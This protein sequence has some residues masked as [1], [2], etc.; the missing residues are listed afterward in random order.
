MNEFVFHDPASAPPASRPLLESAAGKFGFVPSLLAGLAE[1]PSALRAYLE[2]ADRFSET[3]LSP[4]EQQVVAL[5]VSV[6]NACRFCV[7]A[8]SS[9]ARRMLKVDGAVVDALRA[10]APIADPKLQALREFTEQL[11]ERSGEVR[12]E[13]L[14][15]FLAAGFSLGQAL[16]V[17]VGVTMKT[18]SNFA[19][20]MME[21]PVDEAFA[22]ER[23]DPSQAQR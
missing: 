22:A 9:I 18:L 13:A 20:H 11:V 3:H 19:N 7:A 12:G 1:S 23:W 21:T 6:R 8:H 4:T 15:A 17:L 5:T 16:D 10:G 14:D 2:L